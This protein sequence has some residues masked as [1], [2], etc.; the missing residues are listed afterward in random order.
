M[1]FGIDL[2]DFWLVVS[3]VL[4]IVFCRLFSNGKVVV[5]VEVP[6]LGLHAYDALLGVRVM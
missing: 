1:S 3:A 4:S 6:G 5:I 2:I